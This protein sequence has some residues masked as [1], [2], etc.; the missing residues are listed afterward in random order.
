MNKSLIVIILTALLAGGIPAAPVEVGLGTLKIG[1]VLQTVYGYAP[2][3]GLDYRAWS[4]TE[5]RVRVIFNGELPEQRVKYLVQLEAL[6]ASPLLDARV[7]ALGWLPKTDVYVGRFIPSVGYY[8]PRSTA[9]L[10]MVNYPL[11]VTKYAMWRQMGVQTATTLGPVDCNIGVFNGYPANNT[12]DNDPGKDLLV[13]SWYRGPAG[14]QLFGYGWLGNAVEAR[15]GD[16]RRRWFG[17]GAVAERKLGERM[18]LVVRSEAAAGETRQGRGGPLAKSG[19]YYLHM[20]FKPHPKIELLGRWDRFD[21]KNDDDGASWLTGGVNYH[22][23]G[24]NLMLYAN[25]IHKRPEVETP[26][27]DDEFLVQAQLAF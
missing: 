9:A 2:F 8:M 18:L 21:T 10:E 13:S 19:G 20:G 15:D 26:G 25:Y 17:G 5:K 24:T 4:F 11:L 6:A 23:S 27:N 3:S 22:F 12:A 14:I 1:G 16:D 7:Q